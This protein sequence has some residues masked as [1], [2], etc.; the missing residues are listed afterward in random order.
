MNTMRLYALISGGIVDSVIV[1]A[2]GDKIEDLPSIGAVFDSAVD[3]TESVPMPGPWWTYDG[4]SFHRPNNTSD[5]V[6]DSNQ[7]QT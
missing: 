6:L 5:V 3:V 4:Q 7:E 2:T 1:I